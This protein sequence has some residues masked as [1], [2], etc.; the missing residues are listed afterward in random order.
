MRDK[1]QGEDGWGDRGRF[2]DGKGSYTR[3]SIK[4]LAIQHLDGG[5]R[6]DGKGQMEG[7]LG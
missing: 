7:K 4:L 5:Y 1:E 2:L 6:G 3:M